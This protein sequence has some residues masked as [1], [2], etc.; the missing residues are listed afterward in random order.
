[1]RTFIAFSVAGTTYAVSSQEVRHLEMVEEVTRV[2]NVAPYVDGVVF[3]RGRVVPVVSLRARFGFDRIPV[4]AQT[5]LLVVQSGT[6]TVG[7]I[8]DA[9]REFLSIPAERIHPP[10]DALTSGASQYIDGVVSLEPRLIFLLNL[11]RLLPV[12]EP[13]VAGQ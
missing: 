2:P 13:A 11:D 1:M 4:D 6:R 3:T 9:A 8:V 7:L 12:S 10:H 5:R